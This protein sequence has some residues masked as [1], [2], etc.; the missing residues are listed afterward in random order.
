MTSSEITPVSQKIDRLIKRVEDGDIKI[1]A[2]QRGYVWKQ[3]QIID[4]LDS[5]RLDYPIGSILLWNSNER[6]QSTRNIAGFPLPDRTESY[7]VNYVIDGQQRLSS[8]YAV[9]S[10][11]SSQDSS[12]Q[13]YNPD[14]KIFD[15]YYDFEQ[16]SLLTLS[17]YENLIDKSAAVCL[18]NFLDTSAFLDQL[19]NLNKRYH[20]QAKDLYS[21]FSNYEVPVVTIRRDKEEVGIIFERI[22]NTGTKMNMVD[23][24]V[25]WTWSDNFQL[26]E[27]ISELLD[28]LDEK[29]F[30]T[31]PTKVI[32]QSISGIIQDTTK[33]KEILNLDPAIIRANFNLLSRSLLKVVDF[34]YS[35]FNCLSSD[36]LPHVQQIVGLSKF[37]SLQSL[38]SSE[39]V[40]KIRLW[41]W[42]TSFSRRYAGQTDDKM[43]SDLDC[44]IAF[45]KGSYDLLEGYSL[46]IDQKTLIS[47][48]FSKGHPYVRAF[49]LLMA[50]DKPLDL[51]RGT[52][53]D[54]GD[55]LSEFNRKQYHHVFPQAFL[56]QRNFQSDKISSMVN[57]CF[58]PSDSNKRI[59]SKAPSDYFFNV[60]PQS[61]YQDILQS[62]LL[63]INK[64]IY[65][66]NDYE[67]FLEERAALLKQKIDGVT[68][69]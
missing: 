61:K 36:F 8:I 37:F 48:K 7:P 39:Q 43:N 42:L 20:Q 1:P 41:F 46:S 3:E 49:L 12:T 55:S 59:S 16:D 22:N 51:V 27:A 5:I 47:T 10:F 67:R 30:G 57:Y 33:S 52:R 65:R 25:A 24:M 6:L 40:D 13:E 54:V 4:L 19:Q 11:H 58:L 21:K 26:K 15:I 35:E 68:L 32:L 31:L 17:D 62:N 50:M 63:P 34:L 23:I 18:R 38:P 56:K 64:D 66:H 53:I 45:S 29:G 69:K 2:F 9:F 60:I 44:M 14:T 28:K